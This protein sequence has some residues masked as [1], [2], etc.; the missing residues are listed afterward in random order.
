MAYRQYTNCTSINNYIGKWVAQAIVA[1][2]IGVFPLIAAA[3]AGAALAPAILIPILLAIIAYCRWWLFDRLICLGGDRCA[4]G[5]LISVE[6]PDQ[7]SG[8]D[9]FDTDYS[10]NLLLAPNAIGATQAEVESSFQGALI[11]NQLEGHGLDWQGEKATTPN[12]GNPDSAVLHAEFEGA[13]VYDLLLACLIALGLAAIATV[14]CAIPVVGWLA[15]IIM[16]IIIAAVVGIG[17]AVALGDTGNPTDVNENLGN[18]E[19]GVDILAVRGTWVY[20]SAHEGWNELHP[21]KQAQKA[22][23]FHGNWEDVF[24]AV[25]DLLPAGATPNA[26]T[27]V[28]FWCDALVNATAPTTVI[29]QGKPENTWVIHPVIDGC[30]PEDEEPEPPH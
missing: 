5:L 18:L 24:E 16:A 1:A 25:K 28:K 29:A 2:A 15:C 7:K 27:F 6:P 8:L 11:K 19:Q 10:V 22:G 17:M 4:V 14:I 30:K 3:I 20:D 13:G 21:I 9:A 26:E 12:S 23:E